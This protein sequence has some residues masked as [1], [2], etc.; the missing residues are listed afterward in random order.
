MKLT[1]NKHRH[2]R[3]RTKARA[4]EMMGSRCSKCGFDDV[5]ALRFQH[6]KP[7]LRARNGLRRQSMTS[8]KSHLDVVRREGKGIVLLCANCA[9]I[10][11]A[12]HWPLHANIKR[13]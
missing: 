10:A 7:V 12:K 1:S 9:C 4:I 5:R 2:Y 8:T 6:T 11:H 13:A 3:A